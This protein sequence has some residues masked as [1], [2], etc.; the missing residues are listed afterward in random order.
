MRS[1]YL[2]V[3]II[4]SKNFTL[5][6]LLIFS[7]RHTRCKCFC[8]FTKVSFTCFFFIFASRFSL[9]SQR[10]FIISDV[11]SSKLIALVT[12]VDCQA[13]LALMKFV[14][15]SV[16]FIEGWTL[17][18]EK[19]FF[20]PVLEAVTSVAIVFESGRHWRQKLKLQILLL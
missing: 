15:S 11:K 7:L 19:D 12:A 20:K 14:T 2:E 18:A 16:N 8:A 3:T 6:F 5:N 13:P 9:K 17:A 4:L 10:V 1:Y